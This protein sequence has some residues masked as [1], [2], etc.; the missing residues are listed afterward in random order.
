MFAY[1]VATFATGAMIG[2]S[3]SSSQCIQAGLS[4]CDS[5]ASDWHS[6]GIAAI[7]GLIFGALPALAFS[8]ADLWSAA[9]WKKRKA[10]FWAGLVA[11]LVAIAFVA[12]VTPMIY[13]GIVWI[14]FIFLAAVLIPVS[15]YCLLFLLPEKKKEE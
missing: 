12:V 14:G 7:F 10:I 9:K 8:I 11:K 15:I 5:Y 2:L 3:L 6:M 1:L 13:G 4:G